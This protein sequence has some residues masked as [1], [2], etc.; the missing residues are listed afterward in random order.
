MD[1]GPAVR[2]LPTA[3]ANLIVVPPAV[4]VN[5][6]KHAADLLDDSE[7]LLGP[8]NLRHGYTN[9]KMGAIVSRLKP[10]T[11]RDLLELKVV[12]GSNGGQTWTTHPDA[13]SVIVITTAGCFEHHVVKPF[14]QIIQPQRKPK[15]R[16]PPD[17][18]I[19]KMIF[20]WSRVGTDEAHREVSSSARTINI[21]KNM[22]PGVRKWFLTGT[23]FE[24]SP[25]QMMWWISTLEST[26]V[27]ILATQ[28][29]RPWPR[30]D[31]YQRQLNACKL[32]KI[33]ELDMVH[34]RLVKDNVADP[35][36]RKD[37]ALRL[38]TVLNT[39]WLKRNAGLSRFFRQS[40]TNV[41]PNVHT[42]VTC[43]LP[44]KFIDVVNSDVMVVTKGLVKKLEAA[45]QEWE[46]SWPRVKPRPQMD[47]NN[48][49]MKNRRL[50]VISSFP[51]L[52]TLK[53]TRKL[54]LTGEE[55][56]GKENK[57]VVKTSQS[58]YALEETESPYEEHLEDICAE[59]N[60]PKIKAINELIDIKWDKGEKAVFCTMGPV[61]ALILYWV[62]QL[63][64]VPATPISMA[65]WS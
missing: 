14:S 28:K 12:Q 29:Q 15:A 33:K 26:W 43:T 46:Q 56:M 8:W 45:I 23:P 30:R 18:I 49:L 62:S 13:S 39:L 64:I 17:P 34:R 1:D 47:M 48:W 27:Q 51:R 35:Q 52:G 36:R 58:T 65:R 55:S 37:H 9:S 32:D 31:H 42:T 21:F 24:S 25:G 40:L 57:W 16:K 53:S 50:R 7:P 41:P 2:L 44:P 22:P 10:E 5:W 19:V 4:L 38:S 60:C 6:L 11:D 61:N 59:D 63:F 20:A 3:G 54:E